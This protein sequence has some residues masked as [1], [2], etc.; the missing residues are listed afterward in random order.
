MKKNNYKIDTQHIPNW[1]EWKI[2]RNDG[3]V[4]F[5]T[6]S[7]ELIRSLDETSQLC[8]DTL[9]VVAPT[10]LNPRTGEITD[11]NNEVITRHADLTSQAVAQIIAPDEVSLQEIKRN[12]RIVREQ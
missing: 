2:V 8:K 7:E 11:F 1:V 5:N 4:V 6:L 10:K 3:T 9:S 12:T